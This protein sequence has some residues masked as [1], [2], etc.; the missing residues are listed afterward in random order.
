[1][2]QRPP[3]SIPI[4]LPAL[5][6]LSLDGP[7]GYLEDL[8]TRIDTPLLGDGHLQFY[9]APNF[10]TPGVSQFIHRTGMFN[11]PS[12]VDVYIR[13]AVHFWLLSSIDPKKEFHLAFSGLTLFYIQRSS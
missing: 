8:L 2:S 4:V 12:K 1:M 7:H 9:D 6:N 3:P 11:L 5:T 13:K 10:D